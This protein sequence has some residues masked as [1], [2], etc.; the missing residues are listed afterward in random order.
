MDINLDPADYL[1]SPY[2]AEVMVHAPE[3]FEDSP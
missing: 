1:D 2:D 3:L